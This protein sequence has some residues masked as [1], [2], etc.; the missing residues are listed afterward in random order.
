MELRLWR[1]ASDR[2]VGVAPISHVSSTIWMLAPSR[3]ARSAINNVKGDSIP[4]GCENELK[5]I[6]QV[7]HMTNYCKKYKL[8]PALNRN[9]WSLS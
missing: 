8:G 4:W 1:P 6:K 2:R 5:G 3:A 9:A 7:L